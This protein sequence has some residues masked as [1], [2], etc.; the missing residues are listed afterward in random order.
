MVLR[1]RRASGKA[2]QEVFN[3]V[4]TLF[5]PKLLASRSVLLE[6]IT[7]SELW[8]GTL[9]GKRILVTNLLNSVDV[10]FSQGP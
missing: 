6:V 10:I 3:A 4:P 2:T 1:F 8:T 7:I 5:P 9:Q